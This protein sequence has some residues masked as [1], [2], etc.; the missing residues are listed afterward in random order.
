MGIMFHG[1]HKDNIAPIYRD[2][3]HLYS[4]FTS[5]LDSTLSVQKP[6]H[7]V[8]LLAMAVLVDTPKDLKWEDKEPP[9]SL[10]LFVV[11]A[12]GLF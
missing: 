4:S 8:R 1:T 6:L 10:P 11:M 2:G 9:Y 5:S 7:K 3:I 12:E